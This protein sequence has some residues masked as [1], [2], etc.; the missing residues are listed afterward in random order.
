MKV[1]LAIDNFG[2]EKW[3]D[4]ERI[5]DWQIESLYIAYHS[6]NRDDGEQIW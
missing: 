3:R 2:G 4:L 5:D 6:A 1:W